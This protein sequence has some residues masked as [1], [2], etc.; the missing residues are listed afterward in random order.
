MRW[1]SWAAAML[2]VAAVLAPSAILSGEPTPL[3]Q[4]PAGFDVRRPGVS[5]GKVETVEY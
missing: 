1:N 2:G 4:P 3:A 5:A